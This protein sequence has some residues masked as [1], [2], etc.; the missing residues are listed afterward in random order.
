MMKAFTCLA[1][2]FLASAVRV[3]DVAEK[4]VVAAEPVRSHDQ[5]ILGGALVD[6]ESNSSGK[7]DRFP[8][9]PSI[10]E[11][12]GY[13]KDAGKLKAL[14]EKYQKYIGRKVDAKEWQVFELLNKRRKEGFVCKEKGSKG[15][16]TT[17]K[18]GEGP[19]LVFDCRL[20]RIA[21]LYSMEQARKDERGHLMVGDNDPEKKF[22]KFSFVA[23]YMMGSPG[24]EQ[25]NVAYSENH[26][27]KDSKG[28]SEDPDTAKKVQDAWEDSYSH[29]T[30]M[31][32]P[33]NTLMGV[34]WGYNSE[35]TIYQLHQ[36]LELFDNTK[37]LTNV[38]KTCYR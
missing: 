18:A 37:S 34:G 25:A 30:G 19:Q 9:L 24:F 14:R 11:H 33:K 23:N 10:K 5:S 38:D 8:K 28:S 36:W 12:K 1:G 7:P 2:C 6:F 4:E 16:S 17:Y 20:W 26:C 3:A 15:K 32:D 27:C 22:R 35:A 31:M 21:V 29:C 13:M